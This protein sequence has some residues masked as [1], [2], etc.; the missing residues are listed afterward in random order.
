MCTIASCASGHGDCDGAYPNG[1]ETPLAMNLMNCGACG[2]T[3]FLEC[4][5][6]SCNEATYVDAGGGSCAVQS[7]GNL[8]CWGPNANGQIGDG[9]TIQRPRPTRVMIDDVTHV[10][11]GRE[12][13][14][15]ARGDFS[16]WCW[17]ENVSGQLG[18]GSTVMERSVPAR[19]AGTGT[20]TVR[21]V[22]VGAGNNFSCAR[23]TTGGVKCWGA[24][25]LGQLG[26]GTSGGG[27]NTP[28]DVMLGG[29]MARDLAVG[30]Q[31]ACVV[32]STNRVLCWGH[33]VNGQLGIGNFDIAYD[34]PQMNSVT[35][36][37]D[38]SAGGYHSCAARSSG[39]VLCW[40]L[41]DDGQ[42]GNGLTT[43]SNT[44]VM[45]SVIAGIDFD[46]VSVGQFHSCAH[47]TA[48]RIYCWGDN[49]SSQ[50]GNGGGADVTV[51]IQIV[52]DYRQVNCGFAHCCG[53]TNGNQLFCWGNGGGGK[54]GDGAL[55]T[56][57][58]PTAVV[59]IPPPP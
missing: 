47:T 26:N 11:S 31:H 10:S 41:N 12:H 37:V 16:A 5:M 9:T 25:N 28:V 21:V 59:N 4:A 1:C 50:L 49:T 34:T 18:D 55:T 38:V 45:A 29:L 40:G 2:N 46:Q 14:C 23:L 33:N 6:G 35:N 56:R 52:T 22:Q 20:S 17:G 57:A 43:T 54:I 30:R 3:C 32:T 15:A 48:D 53:L 36:A 58:T 13:T 39:E 24:N 8:A 42:L 7:N 51:P 27:S 19:V 44:P